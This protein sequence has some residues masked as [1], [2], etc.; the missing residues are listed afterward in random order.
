MAKVVLDVKEFTL[1]GRLALIKQS[2]REITQQ[3]LNDSGSEVS[4]PIKKR[5][6]KR[7]E[8]NEKKQMKS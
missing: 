3:K 1:Q 8:K 2:K 4:Y 6:Q 5:N 7:D